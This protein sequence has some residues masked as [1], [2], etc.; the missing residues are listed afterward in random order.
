MWT[1]IP[2][3]KVKEVAANPTERRQ[4][5]LEQMPPQRFKKIRIAATASVTTVLAVGV[6]LPFGLSVASRLSPEFTYWRLPFVVTIISVIVSVP[7]ALTVGLAFAVP[8]HLV[9]Q[10]LKLVSAGVYTGG[11]FVASFVL[12]ALAFGVFKPTASHY[13]FFVQLALISLVGG[14]TAG[15]IFWRFAVDGAKTRS[16]FLWVFVLYAMLVGAAFFE[17]NSYLLR[18]KVFR[19]D[20]LS[21]MMWDRGK[22]VDITRN[23]CDQIGRWILSHQSAWAVASLD[24]YHPEKD[25]QIICDNYGVSIEGSYIVVGYYRSQ[26]DIRNDPDSEIKIKRALTADEQ[27]F[28][29]REIGQIEVPQ[30][31]TKANG[32]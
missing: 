29:R 16:A 3:G 2:S 22:P 18:P 9:M 12:V 5:L 27:Q 6:I 23:D 14:P 30:P 15:F 13:P 19:T 4:V 17:V 26:N 1:K 8:F 7:I 21:M 10:R 11:A 20:A 31:P 32:R 25:I 28:W 24:D